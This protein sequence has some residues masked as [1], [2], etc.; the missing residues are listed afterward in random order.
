M[1]HTR[2]ATHGGATQKN[3]HPHMST[4]VVVVHNGIIEN[5]LPLREKLMTQ[6]YKFQSETDTE[7][8]CHLIQYEYD[9]LKKKQPE[10]AQNRLISINS[11]LTQMRGAFAFVV[12]F[13][14][15]PSEMY[16]ACRGAP[17]CFGMK[18]Q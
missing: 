17:L 4:Q 6:G 3:A 18:S 12:C 1:G 14:D 7:V 9:Q 10:N 15:Q 11:A 13:A 8:I 16:A 2:W 5:Y